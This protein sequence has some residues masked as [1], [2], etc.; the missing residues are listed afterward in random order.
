VVIDI[1]NLNINDDYL[2]AYNERKP[3]KNKRS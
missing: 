3:L 2:V 1:K